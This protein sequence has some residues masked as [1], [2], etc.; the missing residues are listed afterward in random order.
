MVGAQRMGV[1]VNVS[2]SGVEDNWVER[3][4]YPKA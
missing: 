4:S 3:T 2:D 1:G